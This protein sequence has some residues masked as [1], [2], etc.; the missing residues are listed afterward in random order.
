MNNTYSIYFKQVFI[1]LSQ[2]SKQSSF[3]NTGDCKLKL[4]AL[5]VNI[6]KKHISFI[7]YYYTLSKYDTYTI[8]TGLF[9]KIFDLFQFY[10]N[11]DTPKHIFLQK[12][13]F[14]F[15]FAHILGRLVTLTFS[16]EGQ[17]FTKNVHS[18]L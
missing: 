15:T 5:K 13:M 3:V 6:E 10:I 11:K 12:N 16:P 8:I 7:F 14:S 4:V 2:T 9:L 17:N 18:P 1:C